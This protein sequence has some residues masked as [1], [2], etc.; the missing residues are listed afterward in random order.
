MAFTVTFTPKSMNAAQFDE[1]IR[2]LAE[3]GHSAPD[4]RLFHVCYGTDDQLQV[5]D[6]WESEETFGQ[7]GQTLM[8][9]LHE[10][11]ID[12]G[13]PVMAPIHYLVKP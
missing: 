5:T 10:I 12:V 13:Q 6:V 8:P 9:I 3:A 2:R 1:I 4:G 7:F 11:G